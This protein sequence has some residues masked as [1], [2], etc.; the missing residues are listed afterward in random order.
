M[1]DHRPGPRAQFVFGMAQM[2]LAP[3]ALVLLL[4]TGLSPMAIG[5]AIGTTVVTITSRILFRH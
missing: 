4:L 3:L 2:F 1:A 5:T